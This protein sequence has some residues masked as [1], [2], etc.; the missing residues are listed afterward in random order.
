MAWPV[1]GAAFALRPVALAVDMQGGG[2]TTENAYR[3]YRRRRKAG[4]GHL[5]FLT[6]GQGGRHSDRV[7]MRAPERVS[8]GRRSR[9]RVAGDIK[10]LHMATDRLKDACA[11]SLRRTEDG[12]NRCIIP[13]WMPENCLIEYT[14]ERRGEKGWEKRPGM[15][16]NESLDHLVQARA[17]HIQ[18][19]GE[20]INWDNP[21]S[22]AIG[23]PENQNAV[24]LV[25]DAVD[26]VSPHVV[27]APRRL[28]R[29]V[30]RQL[31]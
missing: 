22:W 29:R 16:R 28:S 13:E 6:R 18:L 30:P 12:E 26:D 4:L 11:S 10:I 1:D 14:A 5:W 25:G 7:W 20:K 23:G 15:V 24:P 17:L 21:A 19:G 2:S 8:G 3:F 9:R 27:S 31:F